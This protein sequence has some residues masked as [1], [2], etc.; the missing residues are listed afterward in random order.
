MHLPKIIRLDV[1]V[2]DANVV[3]ALRATID[4]LE[5]ENEKLREEN[6]RNSFDLVCQHKINI[7]LRDYC[8]EHGYRVPERLFHLWE[9]GKY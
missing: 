5:A 1:H 7:Q 4:Q 8:V 3:K 9:S 2:E 6:R